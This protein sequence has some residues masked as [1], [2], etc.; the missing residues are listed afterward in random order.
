MI[1]KLNATRFVNQEASL[2][3]SQ[4]FKLLN[5][6]LSLSGWK[7]KMR[8][9]ASITNC[10]RKWSERLKENQPRRLNP[11]FRPE[12]ILSTDASVFAIGATLKVNNQMMDFHKRLPPPVINQSSNYRELFAINQAIAH[13]TNSIRNQEIRNLLIQSDNTTAVYNLNRW[14]AGP[15]L[16]NLLKKIWNQIQALKVVVKAQHI[17]GERNV[18]ADGLSRLAKGGDYEVEQEALE[19]ITNQLQMRITLDAFAAKENIKSTRWCR[20]GSNLSQDGLQ[21]SWRNET[22][23]AHPPVP[24]I[25]AVI[26]KAA[27]EKARVLLLLPDWKGHICEPLLNNTNYISWTWRR[28]EET[29]KEKRWMKIMNTTLPPGRLRICL[30]NP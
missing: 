3:L 27:M 12:A 22:V 26:Q 17:P 14:G 16:R 20:S 25:P 21:I 9:N 2:N 28:T 30:I 19:E 1:G 24:L 6:A 23:L 13:F 5:E 29:I 7:G 8:V 15:N 11:V 18:R 4:L 10:L